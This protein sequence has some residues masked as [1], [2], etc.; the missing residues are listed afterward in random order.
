MVYYRHTEGEV[1]KGQNKETALSKSF[2][3]CLD[4]FSVYLT[5]EFMAD[6]VITQFSA[7]AEKSPPVPERGTWCARAASE[8]RV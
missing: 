3:V 2:P 4:R 6:R 5:N 1:Q 7:T 8:T